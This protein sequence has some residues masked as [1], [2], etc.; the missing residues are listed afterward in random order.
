MGL[1]GL[2]GLDVT[3]ARPESFYVRWVMV[4]IEGTCIVAYRM[5]KKL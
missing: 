4:M 2:A 3:N 5:R 1:A